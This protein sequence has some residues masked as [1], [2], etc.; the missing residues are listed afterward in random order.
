[1]KAVAAVAMAILWLTLPAYAG[2]LDDPFAT[3]GAVVAS[4]QD[5]GICNVSTEGRALTLADVVQISLC[6]NPQTRAAWAT[7]RVRAAQL[8]SSQASLLPSL[9]VQGSATHGASA[10]AGAHSVSNSQSA[11]LSASYLLYDFGGR[12]AGIDN[13]RA[14]LAAANA[15][16]DATLQSV[17]L[18]A[19]QAYFSL[20]SAKA[21]VAASRA[22]EATARESLDAAET[23][24]RIGAATPAD[25]LQAKTALSQARL[26]RIQAEGTMQSAFGT[27]ANAMGIDP[28]TDLSFAPPPAARPE[29]RLE[30]GVG[31]L[32]AM[33]REK[34]PDLVAA[35]AQV[36]AARASIDAARATGRPSI[37]LNGSATQGRSAAAGGTYADTR[38]SS[39]T[40]NLNFPIFTGFST[41][42][43]TRAAE[44]QLENSEASRDL[45]NRQ[46]SLQVWQAYQNLRT[47]GQALRTADDLLAS[48][49]ESE[50]LS[51]GRYRAGVGTIID[52]LTAQSALASARQQHVSALYNWHAARF[53]LAQAIGALDLTALQQVRDSEQ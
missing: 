36:R 12:S 25:R 46:V 42:Y 43:Q 9:S 50:E 14:L 34:R 53:A 51:L 32:I 6:N 47:Q 49:T 13:A 17:F 45:L 23:R 31:R 35:E 22:S 52:L 21:T 28:T 15:S 29:I 20:M 4:P 27:L 24:Y 44:A 3:G 16:G 40:L 7:A 30:K 38:N 8:G 37:T 18:S 33:A 41:Q 19:A 1:M 2:G 11:T 39:V 48:A 10:T 5:A 26:T